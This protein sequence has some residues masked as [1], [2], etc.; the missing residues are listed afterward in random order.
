MFNITFNRKNHLNLNWWVDK[1]PYA[2]FNYNIPA[3]SLQLR[4][5]LWQLRVSAHAPTADVVVRCFRKLEQHYGAAAIVALHCRNAFPFV[6]DAEF[7]RAVMKHERMLRISAPLPIS[8]IEN[9]LNTSFAALAT[10]IPCLLN[11]FSTDQI[12][13][14]FHY[15]A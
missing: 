4:G 10:L 11:P 5:M 7:L 8:S 1:M 6:E 12:T 3:C 15:V 9:G 14:F 2:N 13:Y